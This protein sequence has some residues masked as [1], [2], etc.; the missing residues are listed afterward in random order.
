MEYGDTYVIDDSSDLRMSLGE[1]I[2]R[3]R[4]QKMHSARELAQ[5]LKTSRETISNW[6]NNKV[7]I[8]RIY[9]PKIEEYLG[10][11]PK[12]FA[13][14]EIQRKLLLYRWERNLT[15]QRMARETNISYKIIMDIENGKNVIQGALEQCLEFVYQPELQ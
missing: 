14:R 4:K 11:L 10:Y 2:Q 8:S 9:L 3:A 13:L 5:Y 6:E 12:E 7:A 15:Q 1:Y